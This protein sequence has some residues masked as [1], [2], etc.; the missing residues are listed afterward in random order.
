MKREA[1]LFT[2]H[3]RVQGVWFRDSTRREAERLA[4]AGHAINLPDGRVEVLACGTPEA[5][6][7]LETWLHSGPPMASVSR[8]ESVVVEATASEGF[9]IG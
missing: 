4:I 2:V 9:R 8:V 1:R 6:R 7:E 3:G 5:V